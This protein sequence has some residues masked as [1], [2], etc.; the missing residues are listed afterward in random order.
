MPDGK[1]VPEPI[2]KIKAIYDQSACVVGGKDA[3]KPMLQSVSMQKG[4]LVSVVLQGDLTPRVVLGPGEL[5]GSFLV[6]V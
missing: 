4:K 5:Y 6:W 3:L 2:G 1:P